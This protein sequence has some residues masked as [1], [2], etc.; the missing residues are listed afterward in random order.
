[1]TRTVQ[2]LYSNADMLRTSCGFKRR[3]F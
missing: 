1:L 3:Y 2:I